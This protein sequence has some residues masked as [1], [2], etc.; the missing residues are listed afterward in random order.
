[1]CK[2]YYT[3]HNQPELAVL[4]RLFNNGVDHTA[5]D[6]SMLLSTEE[7]KTTL[8]R[9]LLLLAASP[10]SPFGMAVAVERGGDRLHGRF[11]AWEG[12]AAKYPRLC[13]AFADWYSSQK[14][15]DEAAKWLRT[16]IDQSPD[17]LTYKLLARIYWMQGHEDKWVETLEEYLNQPD[18]GLSHGDVGETIARYYMGRKNWSKAM[19]YADAAAETYSN[20][21][22]AVAAECHEGMRQWKK[23]EDL[24]KAI[25]ERY[26][27][28]DIRL[29]LYLFCR[30]TGHGDLAAARSAVQASLESEDGAR[31]YPFVAALFYL[32]EEKPKQAA[33]IL[34]DMFA[35]GGAIYPGLEAAMVYD[36]LKDVKARDAA[37]RRMIAL[38]EPERQ[39]VAPLRTA[40][41]KLAKLILADLAAGG[42]G[43]IDLAAADKI[44][45]EVRAACRREPPN[46][47][48]YQVVFDYILGRYLSLHGKTDQAIE[49]WKK[50]VAETEHFM[51][52]ARSL[53]GA[54]LC[55]HGVKPESYK[56]LWEKSDAKAKKGN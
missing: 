52:V 46:E 19:R 56:S 40:F 13:R 16:A 26:R 39:K 49:H 43:E 42:K 1:M 47:D 34:S 12:T 27:G 37:L 35:R 25:A 18:Y 9:A 11:A 4:S 23:A 7:H 44:N 15:F 28:P 48:D 22:L 55:D 33:P 14:Q 50:C 8:S 45:D 36:E 32:L 41:G 51:S 38:M 31:R 6:L 24:W 2:D 30:R 5:R 20:W 53:A 17:L 29:A 21:G 54:E 3:N 10:F